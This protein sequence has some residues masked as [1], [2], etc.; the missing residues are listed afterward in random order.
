MQVLKPVTTHQKD[1]LEAKEL[2]KFFDCIK[3]VMLIPKDISIEPADYP[4]LC[5][6]LPKTN[7]VNFLDYGMR[8]R[9][10][11][12][13]DDM[14]Q[15]LSIKVEQTSTFVELSI[16]ETKSG[17]CFNLPNQP[18]GE[19]L[20]KFLKDTKHDD[21]IAIMIAYFEGDDLAFDRDVKKSIILV[22]DG[23]VFE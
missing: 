20:Y 2:Q 21:K 9:I 19:A 1:S 5:L 13:L 6:I 18:M 3:G 4:V 7:Y 8:D 12:L 22:L 16:I 17:L 15:I 14:Y 23:Y 11:N 10:I